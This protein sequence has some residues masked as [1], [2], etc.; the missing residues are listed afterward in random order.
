MDAL[1][2]QVLRQDPIAFATAKAQGRAAIPILRPLLTHED[3]GVRWI[4]IMALGETGAPE[5][6]ELSL[7]ALPDQDEQVAMT[8]VSHLEKTVEAKHQ[9]ALLQAYDRSVYGKVRGH[10]ALL[11][12]KTSKPV[13][14]KELQKRLK[15]EQDPEAQEYGIVALARL[16]DKPAREEFVKR[17]HA[18]AGRERFRYL[19]H[20]RYLHAAWVLKPLLPLLD[21][22]EAQIN[23]NVDGMP[24]PRKDVRTCDLAVTIT[25]EISGRKFSFATQPYGIYSDLQVDEV[26]RF[27]KALP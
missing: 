17:L 22:K 18:S 20:V 9:A 14:A 12:A 21:D 3:P 25:A 4:A 27:L 19:G 7:A 6:A 1:Q 10:V 15:D 13:D 11:I 16:E 26:R 8:A 5:I 24:G 2:D 23:L